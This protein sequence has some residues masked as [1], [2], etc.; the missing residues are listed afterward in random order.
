MLFRPW[1]QWNLRRKQIKQM[2]LRDFSEIFAKKKEIEEKY[3][4]AQQKF[5]RLDASQKWQ[6]DIEKA[7]L[8]LIDWLFYGKSD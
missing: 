8:E 5:S 3:A 2:G 1:I 4:L 7:K 6:I